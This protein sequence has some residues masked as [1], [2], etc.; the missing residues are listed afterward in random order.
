MIER[1]LYTF[2][3]YALAASGA[4]ASELAGSL[5]VF[6]DG[7]IHLGGFVFWL[8]ANA[9]R[10]LLLGGLAAMAT[11]AFLAWGLGQ[12]TRASG[13]NPF[14]VALA[15]NAGA[16]ATS[17]SLSWLIFGKRGEL[18]PAP[19][20]PLFAP[21]EESGLL[22]EIASLAASPLVWL[23]FAGILS[24]GIFIA[25]SRKGLHLRAAGS[26]PRALEEWGIAVAPLR[27]LSW[28]IAGAGAALAGALLVWR[29]AAFSPSLAAGRG[30]I[31]LAIVFMGQRRLSGVLFA[32][33]FFSL[34]ELFAVESRLFGSIP[35]ALL[36]AVPALLALL[37]YVVQSHSRINGSPLRLFS[38]VL[39]HREESAPPSTKASR[40]DRR[41]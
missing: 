2:L 4:L 27:D 41:H 10:S 36:Q 32:A 35:P 24:L 40:Q 21:S 20:S 29:L 18:L 1:I 19:G 26:S 25:H 3:P 34:A 14:I 33:L 28:M 12:W 7:F 13:S 17:D 22:A 9:T 11:G 37:L 23:S 30:W 38:G 5:A 39:K 16:V 8:V 15:V 31:A 6:V